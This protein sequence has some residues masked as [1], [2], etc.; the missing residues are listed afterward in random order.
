M[1]KGPNNKKKL[2]T[3]DSVSRRWPT[4]YE[5]LQDA[6]WTK[7]SSCFATLGFTYYSF[8]YY[9]IS[10]LLKNSRK[11]WAILKRHVFSE[12]IAITDWCVRCGHAVSEQAFFLPTC[13]CEE[14]LRKRGNSRAREF[15]GAR[16]RREKNET[17]GKHVILSWLIKFLGTIGQRTIVRVD[18]NF[19]TF[20]TSSVGIKVM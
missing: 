18:I 10:F 17:I 15:F 13:C 7:C 6:H 2:P 8:I 3:V 9:S 16:A 4:T 11:S 12:E 1:W 20:F 5:K 19:D 14:G